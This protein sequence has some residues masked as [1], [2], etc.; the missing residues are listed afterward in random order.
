M[1]S[2]RKMLRSWCSMSSWHP[3][4]S[5]RDN[6]RRHYRI[7]VIAP[8]DVIPKNMQMQRENVHPSPFTQPHV[9]FVV[10]NVDMKRR[11]EKPKELQKARTQGE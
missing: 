11:K 9:S 1:H 7:A 3:G 5:S 2:N 8:Y 10:L 6:T 4:A